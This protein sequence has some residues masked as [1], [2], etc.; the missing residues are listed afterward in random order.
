M[1]RG[2]CV[3]DDIATG[4]SAKACGLSSFTSGAMDGGGTK[5]DGDGRTERI[6]RY[7]KQRREELSRHYM[8]K[9]A[10]AS[11][12]NSTT[13]AKAK[14]VLKVAEPDPHG[15]KNAAPER[16][17]APPSV[18]MT[19]ASRLRALSHAANTQGASAEQLSKPELPHRGE[20][21]KFEAPGP[22]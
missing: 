16:K 4:M 17:S 9:S 6:E 11:E 18:R 14:G 20:R 5:G 7:K 19:R 1:L 13:A 10:G 8:T 2:V 22:E 21:L 12:E 3:A 15:D